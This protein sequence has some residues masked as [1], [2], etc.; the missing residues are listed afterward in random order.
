MV[1][2]WGTL[3]V[4]HV[5][6]EP[7]IIHLLENL[8]HNIG[9]LEVEKVMPEGKQQGED[10]C[11]NE[12]GGQCEQQGHGE[13]EKEGNEER[14]EDGVPVQEERCEGDGVVEGQIETQFDVGDCEGNIATVRSWSSSGDDAN[15]DGNLHVNDDFMEDLVDCDIQEDLGDGNCFG[16]VEVDVEYDGESSTDMSDSDVDDGINTD[17]NRE[18][19]ELV[20]GAESGVEDDEE[21]Y[22]KFVTF[23]MPKSM[24]DYKWDLGTYFAQ[25][26]DLLDAIKTYAIENGRNIRYVKNDKKRIR[27]KCMGA[28]GKCPVMAYCGYMDAIFKHDN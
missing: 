23:T 14:C 17:D 28:K 25:K 13:C 20:S 22:G 27:A 4:G 9:E 26:Q 5:V 8:S 12:G 6:F 1:D 24:V 2:N 18:S 16:D 11:E 21:S 7:E 15:V 19:E 10:E 3:G